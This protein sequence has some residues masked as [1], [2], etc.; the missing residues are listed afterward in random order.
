MSPLYTDGAELRIRKEQLEAAGPDERR[1]LAGVL[2]ALLE[3]L[4]A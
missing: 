1:A 3:K 2:R 4:A